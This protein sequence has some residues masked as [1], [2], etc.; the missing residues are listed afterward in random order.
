MKHLS[1]THFS[2]L[3]SLLL[4]LV[5][6]GVLAFFYTESRAAWQ[7]VMAVRN[8]I[9]LATRREALSHSVEAVLADTVGERAELERYFVG[10][11]DAASFIETLETLARE[12]RV[13]LD[14]ES[15]DEA[16]SEDA[17]LGAV[18]TVLVARGSWTAVSHFLAVMDGLPTLHNIDEFSLDHAD[19][20][21]QWRLTV[22]LTAFKLG[23]Q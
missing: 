15:V 17:T 3:G 11:D 13:T 9:A 18:R 6:G 16:R 12:T 7:E 2:F 5:A 10:S 14:I 21:I 8:D 22:T 1:P 20:P 23:N 19:G 4:L